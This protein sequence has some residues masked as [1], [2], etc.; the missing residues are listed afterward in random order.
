VTGVAGRPF[1]LH[2]RLPALVGAHSRTVELTF[3]TTMAG[4]QTLFDAGEPRTGEK[5]RIA[6]ADAAGAP[7]A[8]ARGP[9][10]YVQL[11]DA[12]LYVVHPGLSDG[13]THHIA[14]ALDRQAAA[15]TVDNEPVRAQV[16]DGSNYTPPLEAPYPLP[17]RPA[18][19]ATAVLIEAGQAD[20][21]RWARSFEGTIAGLRIRP[22]ASP[23]IRSADAVG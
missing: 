19:A 21:S 12:D 11:W 17:L 8:T 9:G 10:L 1:I 23:L 18:T 6:L 3:R 4:V 13:R 20:G 2:E 22:T 16:W 15:I 7:Q 14:V 5:F